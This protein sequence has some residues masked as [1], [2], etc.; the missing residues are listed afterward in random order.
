MRGK[1]S[2][3][4][5]RSPAFYADVLAWAGVA[6]HVAC[7]EPRVKARLHAGKGGTYLWVA[8]PKRQPLPVRL[9]LSA[10]WGP[11][12][13]CRSLWGAKARVDGRTVELTAGARDVAV[14]ALEA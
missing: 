5:D 6:Q 1:A 2:E 9:E 8:N 13:S 10:E 11:F 4:D 12:S 14:I 3:A 7:S